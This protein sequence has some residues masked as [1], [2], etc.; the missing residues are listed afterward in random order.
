M[1]SMYM[2]DLTKGLRRTELSWPRNSLELYWS[3]Q[4]CL[5]SPSSSEGPICAV[6]G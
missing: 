5:S 4:P 1:L 3:S 6:A 2:R